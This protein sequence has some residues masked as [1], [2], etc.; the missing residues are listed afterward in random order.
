MRPWLPRADLS[1]V[2]RVRVPEQHP[3]RV[4]AIG[5]PNGVHRNDSE[6]YGGR[7]TP[8]KILAHSYDLRAAANQN[9]DAIK[10][11]LKEHG[12]TDEQLE[13]ARAKLHQINE[14]MGIY[15]KW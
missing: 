4:A 1:S 10:P 5:V 8:E 13:E 9:F 7:N 12:A 3:T 6:T 14:S 15:K 2:L 11:A